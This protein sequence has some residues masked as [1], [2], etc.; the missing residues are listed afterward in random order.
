MKNILQKLLG[1]EPAPTISSSSQQLK[2]TLSYEE[3]EPPSFIT[4]EERRKK[5]LEYPEYQEYASRVSDYLANLKWDYR[6]DKN[7]HILTGNNCVVGIV[8]S[9]DFGYVCQAKINLELP[10]SIDEW[11]YNVQSQVF[12]NLE[13]AKN[14]VMRN[15]E[16]LSIERFAPIGSRW[17]R[18]HTELDEH[19]WAL[20]LEGER[21]RERMIQYSNLKT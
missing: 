1:C 19:L 18:F 10:A 15:M 17:A 6:E 7:I 9:T 4:Y 3:K 12:S 8:T 14:E 21:Q 16:I 13:I 5:I 2:E 20:V 11:L